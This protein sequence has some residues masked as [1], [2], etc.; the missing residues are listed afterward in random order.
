MVELSEDVRD[1]VGSLTGNGELSP[2]SLVSGVRVGQ[3][4]SAIFKSKRMPVPTSM[5]GLKTQDTPGARLY[6]WNIL[7]DLLRR[8]GHELPQAQKNDITAGEAAGVID[9]LEELY[10]KFRGREPS[11]RE[12]SEGRLIAAVTDLLSEELGVSREQAVTLLEENCKFLAHILV[13]GVK[14]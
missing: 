12:K 7:A 13:K 11:Q 2:E 9:L 1:W 3:L 5:S 8:L 6:N 10:K 14:G 4:V